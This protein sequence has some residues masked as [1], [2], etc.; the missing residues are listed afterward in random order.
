MTH[1][2]FPTTPDWGFTNYMEHCRANEH[3]PF[4]LAAIHKAFINDKAYSYREDIFR[5][6][7]HYFAFYEPQASSEMLEFIDIVKKQYDL[8]MLRQFLNVYHFKTNRNGGTRRRKCKKRS[9]L[10][11]RINR[12]K[13]FRNGRGSSMKRR[14]RRKRASYK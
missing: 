2:S 7:A 5:S 9:Q 3:D 14:T 1:G 13:G 12:K 8:Q 6:L 11:T 10:L 4:H